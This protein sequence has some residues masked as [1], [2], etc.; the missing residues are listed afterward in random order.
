[1]ESFFAYSW[2]EEQEDDMVIRI[3]GI[4]E[5]GGTTCVR[6]ENFTPYMYVELPTT[7]DEDVTKKVSKIASR[8]AESI[9]L[10]YKYNLYNY[11]NQTKPFLFCSFN[12]IKQRTNAMYALKQEM[13]HTS[14]T[15]TVFTPSCHEYNASAILQMASLRNIPMSGW[16]D[17]KGKEITG[18]DKIS[19]CDKEYIVKWKTLNPSTKAHQ[20]TPKILSFDIEVNSEVTS[21]MPDNRP[22][23]VVFQISCVFADKKILLTLGKDVKVDGVEVRMFNCEEALLQ[24]FIDV[25][26]EEKPNVITGYNILGFDIPYMVKRYERYFIIDDFKLAGYNKSE[27]AK[28]EKIKWS[29]SAYKNQEFEYINWEGIVLIDLL[30]IVKRDYKMD[31][32]KLQTIATKFLNAGKDPI[33]YKDIFHAYQTMDPEKLSEVGKYCV[34]DSE[35]VLQLNDHLHCWVSLS[36]MAKVCNV[37]MFTLYTKGQQIKIYSQV[38]K[39]CL[40]ENIVVNSNGYETK[41]NEQYTGAYV[42]DPVPGYY[43]NV[44][45]LD[46]SSLYPTIIIA[47]NICYSTIVLNPDVPDKLCNIFEWEDHVG[48]EHDPL[49]IETKKLTSQIDVIKAELDNMRKQRDAITTKT[50]NKGQRV[51][52]AKKA[53]QKQIDKRKLDMDPLVKQRQELVKGKQDKRIICAKRKYRF[54]KKEVHVGVIPT[55]I[56]NLLSSR[57]QVKGEMKNEADP[58]QKVVLDKKQLAYKVSANSMYGA[59]GVRKGLLP[60]MPGAMCVTYIGR[61]S[62]GKVADLIVKKWEG[63]IVYGDT[64]SNY[65]RFPKVTDVTELWDHAIHVAAEISKEFQAPMKLEFEN[66]VYVKF[67]IL[68][69]KRYM[70]QAADRNGTLD[71]DIGKRG[72]LLVRRD[73]SGFIRNTYKNVVNMIFDKAPKDKI[74]HYILSIIHSLFENTIPHEDY[75]ITKSVGNANGE[76]LDEDG[77]LGDYKVKPLSNDPETRSKQLNGMTEREYYISSC[78]AQVQLAD[79]MKLRGIPVDVGS[80]IEYVV[81]KKSGAK[82]QGKKI[83]E[84]EYFAKRKQFLSIDPLYYL[85]SMINPFDQLLSVVSPTKEF[86]DKQCKYHV[87]YGKV[88]NQL[89]TLFSPKFTVIK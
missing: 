10:I 60:L 76:N 63:E 75:I 72:V 57:K 73:N 35:L 29:S 77:K 53:M 16:I 36:E 33:T 2:H 43:E 56:Q 17:F 52:D 46:F 39:Y 64:D 62:I 8:F 11:S 25:L 1:M 37:E 47:Y 31:N 12:S 3:Y 68:S 24:G 58:Q 59:M 81:L 88:L 23:D 79:K 19:S 9:S 67:L 21:A 18:E 14:G 66:A 48:C 45:P 30:P 27:P 65:V 6:V 83:E 13:I 70:Y 89:N 69:K 20:A 49:V 41:A 26:N 51:C 78:P 42:F 15:N 44:V 85:Q 82:T 28:E 71:P 84:Y 32:Y 86:L 87:T 61:S 40:H 7:V 50:L 22:D 5:T 55:I 74:E 4:N 54:Y 80:R 34:K 38:Y